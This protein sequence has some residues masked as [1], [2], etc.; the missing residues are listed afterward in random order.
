VDASLREGDVFI[1]H[2]KRRSSHVK[3]DHKSQNC[4]V[5][6]VD[7]LSLESGKKGICKP[8]SSESLSTSRVLDNSQGNE[9]DEP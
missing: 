7:K 9:K 2:F 5:D 8:Q 1:I 3:Q 6:A 4:V